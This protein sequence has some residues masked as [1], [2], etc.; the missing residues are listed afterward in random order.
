M[1]VGI[2]RLSPLFTDWHDPG[3][4]Y[5]PTTPPCVSPCLE[6]TCA[7]SHTDPVRDASVLVVLTEWDE[8]RRLNFDKVNSLMASPCI[9]DA[10]NLLDPDTVRRAGFRYQGIGRP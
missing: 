6:W 7:W 5:A 9:V 1:T 10:R 8:L 3:R 4:G 2:H